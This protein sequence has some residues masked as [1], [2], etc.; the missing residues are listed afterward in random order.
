MRNNILLLG[1]LLFL[2]GEVGYAQESEVS[3]DRPELDL[4]IMKKQANAKKIYREAY[5]HDNDIKFSTLEKLEYVIENNPGLDDDMMAVVKRG[6]ALFEKMNFGMYQDD[7]QQAGEAFKSNPTGSLNVISELTNSALKSI[8]LMSLSA[9]IST[10][11][12]PKKVKLGLY[13][14]PSLAPFMI[15]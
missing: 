14:S 6:T 12:K 1:L 13:V 2:A 15:Y 4:L 3:R 10:Y 5:E 9:V 8:R 7:M 11:L